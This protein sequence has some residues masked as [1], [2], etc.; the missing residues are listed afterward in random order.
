[1]AGYKGCMSHIECCWAYMWESTWMRC[2]VSPEEKMQMKGGIRR[3]LGGVNITSEVR[4]S[5]T[6]R[7]RWRQSAS[8]GVRVTA[9]KCVHAAFRLDANP[10][11]WCRD[12]RMWRKMNTSKQTICPMPLKGTSIKYYG[13]KCSNNPITAELLIWS[14][15]SFHTYFAH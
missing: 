1:M 6:V 8:G 11:K 4:P 3:K 13:T 10:H 12:Y 7:E 2:D 9:W 15:R 14:P 5:E